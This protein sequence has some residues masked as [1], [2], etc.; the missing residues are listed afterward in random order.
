MSAQQPPNHWEMKAFWV[1]FLFLYESDVI[2]TVPSQATEIQRVHV[3]QMD[4]A[5]SIEI[6]YSKGTPM[7]QCRSKENGWGWVEGLNPSQEI[8][9]KP[10]FLE[11]EGCSRLASTLNTKLP[12]ILLDLLIYHFSYNAAAIYSNSWGHL[13]APLLWNFLVPCNSAQ[14]SLCRPVQ[15]PFLGRPLVKIWRTPFP[16]LW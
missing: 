13:H 14:Q 4:S 8:L 5:S 6:H 12:G 3:I 2:R 7:D 1:L 10:Q 11:H 9:C 16:G 15:R